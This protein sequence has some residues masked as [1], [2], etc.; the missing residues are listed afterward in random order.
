[1]VTRYYALVPDDADLDNPTGLIRLRPS[2]SGTR[3]LEEYE[4]ST[5]NWIDNPTLMRF[6]SGGDPEPTPV[7]EAQ[8]MEIIRRWGGP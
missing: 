7:T 6:F 1:M 5:G 2:D 3:T 8:A 4:Q